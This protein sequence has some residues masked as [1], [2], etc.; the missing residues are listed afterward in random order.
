MPAHMLAAPIGVAGCGPL[1]PNASTAQRVR[2]MRE[3]AWIVDAGVFT[4]PRFLDLAFPPTETGDYAGFPSESAV[5]QNGPAL[6]NRI[7]AQNKLS[8]R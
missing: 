3:S 7:P 8:K 4:S 2:E 1:T 5:L 6:T